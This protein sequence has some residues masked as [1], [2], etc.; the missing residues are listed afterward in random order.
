MNNSRLE[1]EIIEDTRN[2]ILKETAEASV[3]ATP[4]FQQD[5]HGVLGVPKTILDGTEEVTTIYFPHIPDPTLEEDPTEHIDANSPM[6]MAKLTP[7]ERKRLKVAQGCSEIPTIPSEKTEYKPKSILEELKENIQI[8]WDTLLNEE[9]EKLGIL[10]GEHTKTFAQSAADLG[11]AKTDTHTIPLLDATPVKRPM[12]RLP[13]VYQDWTQRN[14]TML[15][16]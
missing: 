3:Y 10:I 4:D 5:E 16:E 6:E 9:K 1:R 11:S 14:V 12:Y 2:E 8:D 15:S 13:L 7:D